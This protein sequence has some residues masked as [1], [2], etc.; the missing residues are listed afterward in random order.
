MFGGDPYYPKASGPYPKASG[1]WENHPMN[2]VELLSPMV[3]ITTHHSY[4]DKK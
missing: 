2:A 4:G 1:P 3:M